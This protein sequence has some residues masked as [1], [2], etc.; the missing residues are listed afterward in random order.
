VPDEGISG[1]AG[2]PLARVRIEVFINPGNRSSIGQL[3]QFEA[4]F[5]LK[6]DLWDTAALCG[7]SDVKIGQRATAKPHLQQ[8]FDHVHEPNLRMAVGRQL[9]SILFQEGDLHGASNIV[10]ELEE[11]DPTN[12]DVLYAAHQVYSLLANRRFCRSPNW[13]QILLEC[14]NCAETI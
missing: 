9:F 10:H 12:I 11:L 14:I 2:N 13:R 1:C 7:L 8:A 4:A 6:P 3:K 5:R